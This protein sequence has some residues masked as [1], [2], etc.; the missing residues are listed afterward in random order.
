VFTNNKVLPQTGAG[1]C[2]L[3]RARRPETAKH[4]FFVFLDEAILP[5]NM[6]I[7][8]ALDDAFF[9]SALSSRIHVTWALAAGGTLEERPRYNKTRCFDTFPFPDCTEQ[10]VLRIRELGEALDAH[11]KRQQ[12]QHPN[13][14]LTEMY[15][16]LE[17]LRTGEQLSERERVMNEQE[18][19]SVLRQIHD[20]IDAAVA[21]AYDWPVALSDEEIL[22]RLVR[23]SVGRA[24]EERRG[25]VRWLRPEYQRPAA[26][27]AA[28]FGE[29]FEAAALGKAKEKKQ[30]WPKTLPEQARALRQMLATQPG[31]VTPEQLAKKFMR[32]RVER[33][34]ELLQT[35]VS[36]GQAREAE[37]GRFAA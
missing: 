8:I 7:N 24:A 15:N 6:L 31:V 4:R 32:A 9:L 30:E 14:T 2:K 5:D 27:I 23:R 18:L 11:R 37:T 29:G 36:L 28:G 34:E 22:E 25:L 26:G 10:Q 16:V 21:D 19:V 13:L 1:R 12:A 3:V 33:V 17:K 20:D 35:L